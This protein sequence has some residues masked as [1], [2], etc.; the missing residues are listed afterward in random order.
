MSELHQPLFGVVTT[1]VPRRLEGWRVLAEAAHE[2]GL[3]TCLFR[4]EDVDVKKRR[5]RAWFFRRTAEGT[6]WRKAYSRLP[7]VV[8]E[9]VYVHLSR[10]PAV[11]RV[12]RLFAKRGVPLFNPRLGD[13][14]ELADWLRGYEELWEHHPETVRGQDADEVFRLL[15]EHRSVYLKPVFGSAGQGILEIGLTEDGG[16]RVRA[17][18]YGGAQRPL[19]LGF[20][21]E[22]LALFVKEELRRERFILQAGCDLLHIEGGK[23]DLRTHLQRNGDG[24]W[25]CVALIVK[26]GRSGSIVSNYHA[27]GATHEWAWLEEWA[28]RA[29]YKGLPTEERV[30]ELSE[31]IA[32]AYAD[33][34]PE[35]ASIG[36]DLGIDTAGRLWLLDVNSRPGRNILDREQKL[37]CQHLNAEFAA[38]LLKK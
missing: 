28:K 4:P 37:R 5:V 17:A 1:T 10:T 18:K 25:E 26:Q 15:S 24:K 30:I 16:Y 9:N 27:G 12:R 21:P 20:G 29:K 22:A 2:H 8:Y 23:I 35:L 11:R 3:R 14:G 19:D 34:A 13:K 6:F 33:K 36:L 32:A 38:Y 31:G 7:D